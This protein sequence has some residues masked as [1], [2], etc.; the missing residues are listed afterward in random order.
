MGIGVS[1]LLIAVGAILA[2][3]VDY[4]ISGLELSVIGWILLIV[5]V[6]GI[7]LTLV[8]WGPRRRAA[9]ARVEERRVYDDGP[10]PPAL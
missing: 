1:I 7:I 9:T 3:A 2:F 10:P 8:I 4:D 6:L 5:G